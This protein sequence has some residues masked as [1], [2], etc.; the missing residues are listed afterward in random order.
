MKKFSETIVKSDTEIQLLEAHDNIRKMLNKPVYYKY[1]NIEDFAN[2]STTID[3][4]KSTFNVDVTAL[5]IEN[6]VQDTDSME[7]LGLKYGIPSEGV[8]FIKGNFR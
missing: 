7:N 8:Y 1:G 5:D 6:I 3:I 4:L 2:V